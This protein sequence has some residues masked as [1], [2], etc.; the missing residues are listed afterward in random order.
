MCLF[1]FKPHHLWR[2]AMHITFWVCSWLVWSLYSFFHLTD[3]QW[4][5]LLHTGTHVTNKIWHDGYSAFSTAL[6][7]IILPPPP[8]RYYSYPLEDLVKKSK[9]IVSLFSVSSLSWS[10][11]NQLQ[12]THFATWKA[13]LR[14]VECRYPVLFK[15][16]SAWAQTSS[17]VKVGGEG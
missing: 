10:T 8:I 9:A 12:F 4:K 6:F 14:S 1:L 3:Y 11:Q 13:G 5:V 16:Y 2:F 7:L 17:W 15:S